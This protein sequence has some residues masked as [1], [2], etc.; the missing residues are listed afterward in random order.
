LFPAES[1]SVSSL[2]NNRH[3]DLSYAGTY[4]VWRARTADLVSKLADKQ[5][6]EA[7]VTTVSAQ[8]EKFLAPFVIAEEKGG[9]WLG[10]RTIVRQAFMLDEDLP[11]QV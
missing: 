8:L 6:I 3:L 10:L 1:I 4:A 11:V 7:N 9:A 5:H 2:L